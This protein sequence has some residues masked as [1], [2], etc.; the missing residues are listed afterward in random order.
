M[1]KARQFLHRVQH[2]I[3]SD[4]F[5]SI[6][7]YAIFFTAPVPLY[8]LLKYEPYFNQPIFWG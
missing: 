3:H 2:F 5:A 6:V 4:T 1:S 7:S 8:L